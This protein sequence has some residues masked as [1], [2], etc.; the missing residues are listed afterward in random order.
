MSD[1]IKRSTVSH[2]S[3]ISQ[4]RDIAGYPTPKEVK[5]SHGFGHGAGFLLDTE[6]V[7][8]SRDPLQFAGPVSEFRPTEREQE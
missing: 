1:K 8:T 5:G 4:A 2:L 7:N 6:L 3:F